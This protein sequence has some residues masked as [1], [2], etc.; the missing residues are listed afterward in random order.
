V[1]GRPVALAGI[2][3]ACR[4][5]GP[6]FIQQAIQNAND[7][8]QFLV[9]MARG[10]L[11]N[12]SPTELRGLGLALTLG[13]F[14]PKIAN[15]ILGSGD[16]AE[17]PW[18]QPLVGGWKRVR[19]LWQ[20]PLL[21]TLR[22]APPVRDEFLSRGAQALSKLGA[23]EIAVPIYL[24]LK[25]YES[26]IQ[27]MAT[28]VE[29]M[30]NYG[31]WLTLK[32]WLGVIPENVI[33]DQPWL[34]YAQAEIQA[35]SGQVGQARRN[36]A[37]ASR[38]F[39]D[40]QDANG[41]CQSLLA[42]SA[43]A[44]RQGDVQT[45]QI[46]ALHAHLLAHSVGLSWL[47]AWTGWQLG[48]LSV[49]ASQ[50]D[51][52]VRYFSSAAQLADDPLAANLI[53]QSK[54]LAQEQQALIQRRNLHQEELQQAQ[55]SLDENTERME[56]QLTTPSADL[57]A[58]LE[59]HGWL[60]TP[61]ML[62][63]S[64][65]LSPLPEDVPSTHTTV[66]QTLSRLLGLERSRDKGDLPPSTNGL[67][68]LDI[69]LN[70]PLSSQS[71]LTHTQPIAQ[72]NRPYQASDPLANI[73]MPAKPAE[74]RIAVYCLGT[75]RLFQNSR[76]IEN[77]PSRKAQLVLKYLL[78]QHHKP[79]STDVLMDTFWPESDADSA[80]RNLH[81]A[82]YVLRQTLRGE[83]FT[84]P[85]VQFEND[86]YR[87]N[88]ELDL[89]VDYEAFETSCRTAQQMVEQGLADQ[90]EER[91]RV[92]ELLYQDHLFAED[93][94]EDWIQPKRQYLW[95]LYLYIFDWLSKH[96]LERTDYQEAIALCQRVLARDGS[97]EAAHRILI[98]CFSLQGQRQLAIRQY[99]ICVYALKEE[100]GVKPSSE[101]VQL[102]QSLL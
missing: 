11:I 77:W 82:I 100:L 57:P 27:A 89:W 10:W 101:T 58:I 49:S 72:T 9:S 53:R 99:Q 47:R 65:D 15:S 32:N 23:V 37:S 87:I 6:G 55:S 38:L 13:Y 79:I 56:R 97:L 1:K 84:S 71:A 5:L 61:L 68:P 75:F 4:R 85:H 36:F 81:Q 80:R 7:T 50:V 26:A 3:D 67:S 42:E 95:Q 96:Y 94:Y 30:I 76:F 40:K 62:K 18:L 88:P 44:A 16:I 17:G 70:L 59:T 48:C 31:Q 98:Q 86:G 35:A 43:L 51:R 14:H 39:S 74:E 12:A 24:Q 19:A 54:S 73:L 21:S 45:A 28:A 83:D 33:K 93:L 90:A 78:L 69:P 22:I 66:I 20:K 25:D 63:L 102:Y 34:V 64:T 52:A 60:A 41:A 91:F 46:N 29:D 8:D 2:V 92:A